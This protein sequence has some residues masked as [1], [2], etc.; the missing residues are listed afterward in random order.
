MTASPEQPRH[1]SPR[2]LSG[3]EAIALGALH[4][5]IGLATGYPGTPSTD[6]I[7]ALMEHARGAEDGPRVL[8]HV[9]E[10]TALEL[11]LGCALCAGSRSLVAMKH[12]GLNVAADAFKS[13][14]VTGIDGAL[15]LVACDDRGMHSSQNEFDS[16]HYAAEAGCLV[17]EPADAQDAYDMTRAAF[18]LSGD[19]ASLVMLRVTTRVA[20]SRALVRPRA[21]DP[22]RPAP[23]RPQHRPERYVV[24]PSFAIPN[25]R[26]LHEVE[27]PRRRALTECS[28]FNRQTW[29]PDTPGRGAPRAEFGVVCAGVAA[30]HVHEALGGHRLPM[31]RL[32]AVLP[33]PVERVRAFAQGVSRLLVFEDGVTLG[34][35]LRI[36]GFTP[37]PAAAL[38]PHGELT[39]DAVRAALIA[40]GAI[41]DAASP[42]PPA[43]RSDPVTPRPPALCPGCPHRAMTFAAKGHL[44]PS[45]QP[46]IGDIGCSTLTAIPPYDLMSTALEMGASIPMAE[47]VHLMHPELKPVCMI[48]DGTFLHAGLPALL[49]AVENRSSITVLIMDNAT[50]G[51]TGQQEIATSPGHRVDLE[52]LIRGL[53]V[54]DLSLVHAHDLEGCSQALA[55]AGTRRGVSV[56]IVRDPCML[57]HPAVR[58][59]GRMGPLLRVDAERCTLCGN[60]LEIG[61]PSISLCADSGKPV[62]DDTCVG[63]GD[64]AAACTPCPAG[65]P[66]LAFA[67]A[68]RRGDLAAGASAIEAA[69]PFG[70][71]CGSLCPGHCGVPAIVPADGTTPAAAAA[72]RYRA[73][74]AALC[75]AHESPRPSPPGASAPAPRGGR[76]AV[77]GAGPAGLTA[78]RELARRGL[79]VDLYEAGAN[80]GGLPSTVQ[81]ERP[82][83]RDRWQRDVDA[84]LAH[85]SIRLFCHRPVGVDPSLD[86]LCRDYAGVLLCPGLE[87]VAGLRP[88]DSSPAEAPDQTTATA[89]SNLVVAGDA[90]GGAARD[91][92]HAI[93]SA[94][95][96]VERLLAALDVRACEKFAGRS[97][98]V[99]GRAQQGAGG[100]KS[101]SVAGLRDPIFGFPRRSGVRPGASAVGRRI[102]SQALSPGT[103]RPRSESIAGRGRASPD[104]ALA[105]GAPPASRPTERCDLFLGTLGGHGGVTAARLLA[106]ACVAAGWD[107]KTSQVQGMAQRGGVVS[108]HV[109][110]AREP[111]HSP[112][113]PRGAAGIGLF[114]EPLEALRW[115]YMLAP[116]ATV[117]V[118][119][120]RQVPPLASA[121]AGGYPA[122][123]VADLR[124]R[125]PDLAL[126]LPGR[127]VDAPDSPLQTL[128][129][130]GAL[131][132][133][134]PPEAAHWN[135]A[136]AAVIPERHRAATLRALRQGGAVL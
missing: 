9:N 111:V 47:G 116:G 63:C 129:L 27:I 122:D 16:R 75:A 99:S 32:G 127:A 94:R 133:Q 39:S 35:Q 89:P 119:G 82:L 80:P 53:G 11:A 76:I 112:M 21:P 60:C 88:A 117:V 64:C 106:E 67:S 13:A 31:L 36:H 58:A 30:C 18:A 125:R 65:T 84:V 120:R 86:A 121:T 136:I 42:A 15:V 93:G 3:N 90:A 33:L 5:R 52:R 128:F 134:L 118:L 48:G 1:H 28:P 38:P 37:D 98:G 77:V 56:I 55:A 102:S 101:G 57:V 17:L 91:L 78:A 68:F 135:T 107:C 123:P 87:A 130:L 7:E 85:P 73:M 105:E 43:P 54:E 46:L 109:R 51:M 72:D 45:G 41:A 14:A 24:A 40:A 69:H 96:A 113:I 2:L 44:R 74:E 131:S 110:L 114:T 6:L 79:D 19:T 34:E 100:R 61:C 83:D 25:V 95:R 22:P 115:E 26:R 71:A 8:W 50:I 124:E 108:I 70:H 29:V 10:K 49:G 97:E 20:H 132:P 4:A 92:A 12:V 103:E 66:V 81:T 59:Q 104:A 23:A 62:I 126:F